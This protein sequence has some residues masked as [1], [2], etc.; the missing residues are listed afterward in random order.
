MEQG[1]PKAII[2]TPA[3]YG[4][5]YDVDGISFHEKQKNVMNDECRGS[6]KFL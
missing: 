6:W 1:T 5:P 4:M 3:F 2:L